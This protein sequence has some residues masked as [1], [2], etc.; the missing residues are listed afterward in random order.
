M[1]F[2]SECL[3][4]CLE[5]GSAASHSI[6]RENRSAC[7][8]EKIIFLEV[9]CNDGVHLSELAAVAL[10]ED[11]HDILLEDRM[12]FLLLHKDCELLDGRDD[13]FCTTVFKLAFEYRCAG[14]AVGCASLELVIL[15]HRLIVKVFAVNHKENLVDIVELRGELGCLERGQGLA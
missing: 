13:D 10:I 2:V 5:V 9:L 14:I 7:E 12:T 3:N 4:R 8:S 15:F 1:E 11:N 6:C